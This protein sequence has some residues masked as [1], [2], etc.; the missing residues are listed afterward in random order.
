MSVGKVGTAAPEAQAEAGL[1]FPGRC[2]ER[3]LEQDWRPSEKD[4]RVGLAE[5]TW[6]RWLT[7]CGWPWRPY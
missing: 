1:L 7:T 4:L 3:A 2:S 6:Q 5:R